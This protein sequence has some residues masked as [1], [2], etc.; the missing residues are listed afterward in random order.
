MATSALRRFLKYVTYDTRSDEQSTTFPSTPG[1]LVLLR[2][3]VREVQQLGLRD[4]AIDEY[5]YVMA[6]V[7]PTAGRD[8]APVIGF[9]AHVDTSPEMPGHDVRPLVH[10][11]YNGRDLV[12]PDDPAMVLRSSEIP[13]LAA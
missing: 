10:E 6:T 3:L 1:Q 13:A 9:I 11:R 5:C 8:Q 7:A 4:A 2:E 12:I